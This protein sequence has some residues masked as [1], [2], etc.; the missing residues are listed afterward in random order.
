MSRSDLPRSERDLFDE[1]TMSFGEHLEELRTCLIRAA[2]GVVLGTLVGLFLGGEIV[3]EIR[4]PLDRALRKYQYTAEAE[5]LQQIPDRD[6]WDWVKDQFGAGALSDVPATAAEED[7]FDAEVLEVR[8]VAGEVAEQLAA[9]FPE[10]LDP[11]AFDVRQVPDDAELTLALRSEEFARFR[12]AADQ[13]AKPVTLGVPEAFLTYIKVSVIAGILL[14]SPWIFYQVWL[15]V[16][17]GL[18]PH[19][20]SW[21][22]KYGWMSLVLFL[23]GAIFCFYVV[24]PFVLNF[25]LGFNRYLGISPQ[26]Q[27]TQWISFATLLPLVFGLSFQLPLVMLF[28]EKINIFSVTDYREKRKIAI[29]AIAVIS[30]VVTPQDPT[31]MLFLMVPLCLLYELGI[32]LVDWTH[33]AASPFDDAVT[34]SRESVGV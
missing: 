23:V 13:L 22:R 28:L 27:L 32:K 18:Y 26:I 25:M 4:K 3:G 12:A 6:L 33:D 17:A 9:A 7:G 2:Y 15:F 14:S 31:T 24:L 11:D 1:S 8:V 30:M 10:A 21:V 5:T 16:A 29:F 20:R 19:E 34:S